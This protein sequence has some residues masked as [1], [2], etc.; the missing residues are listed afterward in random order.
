MDTESFIKLQNDYIDYLTETIKENM[1]DT[2]YNRFSYTQTAQPYK[3]RKSGCWG[4]NV[5][6]EDVFRMERSKKWFN[7]FIKPLQ[8]VGCRIHKIP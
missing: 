7:E 3:I 1:F 5:E 8:E 2:I 4:I 6:P